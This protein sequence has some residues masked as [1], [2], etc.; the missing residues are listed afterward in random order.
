MLH[1]VRIYAHPDSIRNVNILFV[2]PVS[3]IN[4]VK[5]PWL[6]LLGFSSPIISALK[7]STSLRIVSL[8]RLN[9]PNMKIEF[10][11]IIL[12]IFYSLLNSF[13]NPS[14]FNKTGY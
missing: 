5:Y 2:V 13:S 6:M 7:T 10:R 9:K 3:D 1:P 12:Y 8:Y 4:T 14:Y 11:L